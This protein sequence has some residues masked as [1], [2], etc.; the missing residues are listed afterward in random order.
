[1]RLLLNILTALCLATLVTKAFLGLSGFL[2]GHN[3]YDTYIQAIIIV[4]LAGIPVS[5]NYANAFKGFSGEKFFNFWVVY[6]FCALLLWHLSP[7]ISFLG[8]IYIMQ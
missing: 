4:L 8:I 3:T 1:M 5:L 2:F 6:L 7:W